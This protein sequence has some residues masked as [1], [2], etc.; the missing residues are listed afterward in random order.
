MNEEFNFGFS[1]KPLDQT[2][3]QELD[4]MVKQCF[5]LRAEYEAMKDA[6]SEKHAEYETMQAKV[7]SVLEATGR[8]NHSTPG[9][10]TIS[11]STRSQVSF[12]KEEEAAAALQGD[13]AGSSSKLLEQARRG[14]GVKARGR[15]ARG[16]PRSR[17]G[18]SR[19]GCRLCRR[20]WRCGA[21]WRHRNWL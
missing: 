14:A 10:G 5:A 19:R 16:S 9:A 1:E 3:I 11:M 21:C 13:V 17:L 7:Q 18:Y 15:A 6:A 2:T 8:L 20:Y 4:N 12:P